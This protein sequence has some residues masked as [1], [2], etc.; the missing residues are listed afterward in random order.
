VRRVLIVGA[1][2]AGLTLACALRESSWQ[3][4]IVDQASGEGD[5]GV[6]IVIHPNGMQVLEILGLAG[7][8][9]ALGNAVHTLAIVRGDQ[10][11]AIDLSEVWPGSHQPTL[12][13]RRSQLH[14]VLVSAAERSAPAPRIRHD[15][16]LVGLSLEEPL[17]P[18]ASLDGGETQAYDLVVGADGVHSTVRRL[19]DP[20]ARAVSTWLTF[21]RWTAPVDG[22]DD[23]TWRTTERREGSYGSI[24]LGGGRAHCFVQTRAPEKADAGPPGFDLEQLRSWDPGLAVAYEK[25]DQMH[26]G[27]AHLVR[28]VTW[29]AGACVL[30]G[31]AAHAVS[32]TLT[33]GGSLAAEDALVLGHV[34][35][36]ADPEVDVARLLQSFR[37]AR[38]ARVQW[39]SRMSLAQLNRLARDTAPSWSIDASAATRHLEQVYAP[40]SAPPLADLGDLPDQ[41]R[42]V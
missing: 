22:L 40:M 32:P 7:R 41:I 10:T 39:A 8:V 17:R 25:A 3:V 36:R 5:L 35:D 34:L 1:G 33:Q 24:P 26:S 19:L 18:V 13:I 9:A 14:D 23:H 15:T 2:I 31:D 42:Q 12:A 37:L 21:T 28:P 27:T 16:R 29:G 6:G 4:D 38:A 11:R 30:L 20:T